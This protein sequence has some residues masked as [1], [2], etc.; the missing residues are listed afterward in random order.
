QDYIVQQGI[1]LIRTDHKA[2]DFRVHT[3]K[4]ADGIW[5]VSVLAAKISGRG[6][7]TTHI[8]NGGV[9]RTIE[10]IFPDPEDCQQKKE[11]LE[12]AALLLSEVIDSTQQ[13]NLGE[14]GFDLGI[15][16]DGKVW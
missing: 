6:S 7:V 2:V 1:H 15:D 12:K 11:A 3:N 13:G 5:K 4:D 9:V 14:L 8:N 10:E 16:K